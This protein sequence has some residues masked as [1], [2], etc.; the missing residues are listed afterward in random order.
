MTC[1]FYDDESIPRHN[2]PDIECYLNYPQVPL[3]IAVEPLIDIIPTVTKYVRM[4]KEMC[5]NPPDRLTPDES[6][7]IYLYTIEP[8]G[9]YRKLNEAIETKQQDVL[10]PWFLYLK[11]F[12]VALSK[13]PSQ[14]KSVWRG[15]NKDITIGTSDL[16]VS[17]ATFTW[18]RVTSCSANIKIVKEFMLQHAQNTLIMINCTS[19]KRVDKHS[20]YP[21]EEEIILL[22]GTQL[23]VVG[24]SFE[25]NGLRVIHLHEI[26]NNKRVS[27]TV[28][29]NGAEKTS[30]D[31]Q[32][33]TPAISVTS[34]VGSYASTAASLVST[35]L[36]NTTD[37]IVSSP[38]TT[39]VLKTVTSK[40][41]AT[42]FKNGDRYEGQMCMGMKNGYG[43]Y[44]W[45]S[46]GE[47]IGE[48]KNNDLH[49]YGLRIWASGDEY[50]GQWINNKREGHGKYIWSNGNQYDGDWIN[51]KK[52]G[53]GIFTW[54]SGDKY[55]GQ[56]END[57]KHGH[58]TYTWSNGNKYTGNW[59]EDDCTGKGTFIWLDG[60]KYVG[61]FVAGER[62]GFGI[63]TWQ[64][65]D[66]YIGQWVN[67]TQEGHGKYTWS[68]GNQYDGEWI[69]GRKWSTGIFTWTSGDKYDGQYQNDMKHG[70]G[71]IT[72]LL[73]LTIIMDDEHD[74]NDFKKIYNGL[75][76][77]RDKLLDEIVQLRCE[78]DTN[79]LKDNDQKRQI[80]EAKEQIITLEEKLVR[81]KNESIK[82]SKKRIEFE[83]QTRKS[84]FEMKNT[85]FEVQKAQLERQ[86]PE[87]EK[88]KKY[89]RKLEEDNVRLEKDNAI[90]QV[91]IDHARIES[92]KCV[93][94]NE[95]LVNDCASYVTK[96]HEKDNELVQL[97][98]ERDDEQ[99]KKDQ[100]K[101]KL[102]EFKNQIGEIE[103]QR[104]RLRLTISSLEQDINLY[105]KKENE[106]SRQFDILI[107]ERENLNKTCQKLINDNRKQI[108]ETKMIEQSK[109]TLEQDIKNYKEEIQKQQK[110]ILQIKKERDSYITNAYTLTNQVFQLMDEAKKKK[111]ELS[112]HKQKIDALQSQ[113]KQA[114]QLNETMIFDRSLQ[115]KHSAEYRDEIGGL[116]RK[117]E[118]TSHQMDQLKVEMQ[119]KERELVHTQDE[120]DNV[121]KE[122]KQLMLTIKHLNNESKKREEARKIRQI[123]FENLNKK[124]SK[125]NE[126]H[127]QQIKRLKK[128]ISERHVLGTQLVRRNDELALLY[129]KLKIQQSVV[130]SGELQ[131]KTRLEDIRILKL[132][133][134]KL[135]HEN[136]NL[137]DKLSHTD[138]LKRE[139]FHSQRELIC[140]RTRSRTLEEELQNPMNIHRWR[141]LE[142]SDPSTF[143]LI[144]KVQLLQKRLIQKTEEVVQKDLLIQERE[145]S[146][147]A[148]K[149][150]LGNVNV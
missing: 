115:S 34:L 17:G 104:E 142:G 22:P 135:S 121:K 85:E 38:L 126:E 93:M 100:L 81:E 59:K 68:N 136:S 43:A 12:H 53:T 58:G 84:D 15:I 49:G 5:S 32:S 133:L 33:I 91:E 145:Q 98:K 83:L 1:R 24:D 70:H 119:D 103:Q 122:K 147:A 44:K 144:Q 54:A 13:L 123:E 67:G 42:T 51:D 107:C 129:E 90:L 55:D 95:K 137:L 71:F 48:W 106:N 110:I 140:E 10:E 128:A 3:E 134:K 45:T 23:K 25:L 116:K 150:I 143:E 120:H 114:Q 118:I 2:I 102:Q 139:L 40:I 28:S 11:L 26:E 111:Q 57:M 9:I 36:K 37:S 132:E 64:C 18:W 52:W 101:K 66:E 65:G 99:M 89:V 80:R 8:V 130:N 75:I 125:V 50:S 35:V 39:S 77:E 31:S 6:A 109:T 56:Y 72:K 131:Y 127:E 94:I 61:D 46:G 105:K 112:G 138:D 29:S 82:E 4:A 79:A 19:G 62:S 20:S 74:I 63:Q 97:R 88:T 7:S 27:E 87:F 86:K 149:H 124:L 14:R 148:L 47:Y 146:Y 96:S 30:D 108:D 73:V 69:D 113:L 21:D 60:R 92:S 141:K 41:S 16:F 117:L 78:L 76:Q